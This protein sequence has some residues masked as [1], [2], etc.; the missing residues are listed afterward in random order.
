M[1]TKKKLTYGAIVVVVAVLG[2][3]SYGMIFGESDSSGAMIMT[4]PNPEI[5]KPAA[6][7]QMQPAQPSQPGKPQVAG[8]A[9][10]PITEREAQLMQ[11]QQD[12]QAKYLSALN[13]LQMLKVQKDI[14]ETNK[15]IAKAKLDTVTSQKDIVD[16]LS[17]KPT[18]SEA[19]AKGLDQ[20]ALQR[21]AAASKPVNSETAEYTV[22]SVSRLR[23][24]W[25]AVIG[26]GGA[27]YN[28]KPG[29]ILAADG[30]VVVAIN[31]NGVMLEKDGKRTKISM[32]PII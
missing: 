10:A 32:V 20:A 13:E 24:Q 3:F 29:D 26:S 8:V 18:A 30:S 23:G 9:G 19:Y 2:W 16:L 21:A 28:V 14:A 12:A 31:R 1:D 15:D 7:S 6:M 17:P 25:T 4:K 5:P 27:L 22:I 11:M